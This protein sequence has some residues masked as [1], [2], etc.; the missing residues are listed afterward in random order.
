MAVDDVMIV[1]E[2]RLAVS[3]SAGTVTARPDEIV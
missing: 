1:L 3:T 2:G